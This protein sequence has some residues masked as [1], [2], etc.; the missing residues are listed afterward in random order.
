MLLKN[1]SKTF[2][3][4]DTHFGHSNIVKFLRKDGT[5][6]RPWENIKEHDQALI[7]NWNSAVKPE[8]KV[9]HIGDF[10]LSNSTHLIRIT[11]ALNGTKILI[12][13]NHDTLKQSAYQQVFKDVRAYHSLN[14]ILL[15]HIP[16]HPA[17]LGGWKG[18]IH[19]HLHADFVEHQDGT[20]DAKYYNVACEQI[21]YTPIDFEIV[22]EYFS[23]FIRPDR[24]EYGEAM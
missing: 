8:D 22:N 10:G 15:A 6:L 9:Y 13:G 16:I 7:D 21:N 14:N 17:S 19:G 11:Q 20:A 23:K 4:S 1:M 12:K 2:L 5:K 24:D 3:I 18:Q